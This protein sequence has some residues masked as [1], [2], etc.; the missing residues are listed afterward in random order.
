MKKDVTPWLL[1]RE[2]APWDSSSSAPVP[3]DATVG[4]A[5]GHAP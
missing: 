4:N 1:A 2:V 5:E 3:P